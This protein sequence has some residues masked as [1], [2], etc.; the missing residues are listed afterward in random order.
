[1][2][3]RDKNDICCEWDNSTQPNLKTTKSTI[4]DLVDK[5]SFLTIISSFYDHNEANFS[6]PSYPAGEEFVDFAS[7][8]DL[9]LL[10]QRKAK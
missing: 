9:F 3:F 6:L 7:Y 8:N 1:M 4:R 2:N 5:V 10:T